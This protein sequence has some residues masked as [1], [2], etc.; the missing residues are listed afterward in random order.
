MKLRKLAR[1][2]LAEIADRSRQKATRFVDRV[3]PVLGGGRR[4]T[5]G[6]AVGG[7]RLSDGSASLELFKDAAPRRFFPGL[8]NGEA[9]EILLDDLPGVV[10]DVVAV[11]NSV[12]TRRFD[13]LGYEGLFFGESVDWHLDPVAGRRAP[14]A[15][16]SR[17]DPLDPAMVG[18]SKVTWELNRHQWLLPLA[19]AYWLTADRRYAQEAADLVDDWSR[20]NPYG[21]GLNWSSSLEAA[22]R[23]IS[24]SWAFVLVRDA[25]VLSAREFSGLIAQVRLHATH[26]ERYLSRYF[27]P[28]T[29]L[30]GEALG[31]FYAGVLF[32]ELSESA[33]WRKLGR[34]ILIQESRR[35]VHGDGVF[36]EQATAYQR[37]TI[38]FYL[39]FLILAE[40]NDV[41]VPPD[42]RDVVTRMLDFLLRVSA[43]DGSM[44][45]IGDADGGWL[46]P[47]VRRAPSDARG[48][49]SVAAALFNRSDYLWA[50]GGATPEVLWLLGSAA[51][52]R[53]KTLEPR[54]PSGSPSALFPD[55]GYAVMRSDW[56][57]EAHQLILDVGP[58]G[59]GFTGA[60][61]H[62]DLLSIQC[63]VFGEPYLID[64]GTFCYTPDRTWRDY[65]RGSSAHSTVTVDGL[66][67]AEPRGPFAWESRPEVTIRN[68]SSTSEGD[69]V[70]ASHDAYGRLPDPVRHRRRVLFVKPRFWVVV[71]DLSGT[72]EH[73]IDLRFQFNAGALDASDDRWV[74]A[75]GRR[76]DGLALASFAEAPLVRRVVE[77]EL[78]PPQGWIST[79][80]GRRHPAPM[81]IYSTRC[82]LP[83][84]ITT[85]LMPYERSGVRRPQVSVTHERGRT[86]LRLE[87]WQ[88]IVTVTDDALSVERVP[89]AVEVG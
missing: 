30:T 55:G 33:R 21:M 45:S 67:Q 83:M 60:H 11:A 78:G 74:A 12:C 31:L 6:L 72:A 1:M 9:A 50:A 56:T 46:L 48:T 86:V 7:R 76:G 32:P 57:R 82:R 18:D 88:E 62:A 14:F 24:W 61:G 26:I 87:D 73:L 66:P 2:S 19:Q 68:W 25:G 59:C 53:L 84:R 52:N 51:W 4:R 41:P 27:S 37:Y 35:Q 44:P 47:L 85:L 16:F 42:V 70:D 75:R 23:L 22:F 15:H 3:V 58:M 39:H 81:V 79:H 28:N 20:A 34:E 8:E 80:Y 29:H 54:P 89:A 40:R 71:D 5:Q 38:D 43:P 36:F 65:F 77:G 17:I 13:L 63:S 64:P 49:F 69:L 10:R